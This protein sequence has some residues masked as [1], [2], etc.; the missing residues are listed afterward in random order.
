MTKS[1]AKRLMS[2]VCGA[3]LSAP[4]KMPGASWSIPAVWTCPTGAELACIPGTPC[5]KCYATRGRYG[6]A[7]V[8]DA[9]WRRLA[10]IHK[11]I[12]SGAD[13]ADW[14]GWVTTFAAALVADGRKWFRWHDSGD[15]FTRSYLRLICAVCDATPDVVHWLPTQERKMV[16]AFFR[17]NRRPDNLVIRFSSAKVDHEP[18]AEA[19]HSMVTTGAG[20]PAGAVRC[21][22]DKVGTC[23]ACRACWND[24]VRLVAYPIH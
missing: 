10:M 2:E 5:N 15:V 8:T 16:R 4:S 6:F 7:N 23:G 21:H 22:C 19:P 13:S 1:E 11:V 3:P 12:A 20:R 9:Q 14:Q 18:T 17:Q 24:R